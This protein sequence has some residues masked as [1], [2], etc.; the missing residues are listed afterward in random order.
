MLLESRGGSR[1]AMSHWS[2]KAASN[3]L[4]TAGVSINNPTIS[5]ITL[6]LL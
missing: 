4:M 6:A 5:Y 2:K 3:E 1:T